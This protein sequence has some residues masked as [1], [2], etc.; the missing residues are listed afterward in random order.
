MLKTFRINWVALSMPA[1]G[2]K[3]QEKFVVE[4]IANGGNAAAAA[5]AAG[6]SSSSAYQIGWQLLQKPWVHAQIH[7]GLMRLR[8][9]SG[10]VGLTALV[11][12]AEDTRAPAAARV[13]AARVLMEHAGLVGTAKEMAEA[14]DAAEQEDV[15]P[16]DYREVLRDV[17]RV[18]LRVVG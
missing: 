16:V 6:Y 5:E 13:S 3:L 12:I 9:R 7:K 8:H 2:T 18:G 15:N 11:R 14:R 4:Y 10:V 1:K 17:A